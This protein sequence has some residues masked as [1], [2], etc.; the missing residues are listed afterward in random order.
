MKTCYISG[1]ISGLKEDEYTRN[2]DFAKSIVSLAG[3][4]P[5][6]PLDLYCPINLWIAYMIV[7][8]IVLSFC[9]CVYFMDGWKESRGARIEYKWAKIFRKNILIC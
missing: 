7:D 2:F 9:D 4:K 5:I 3:F 8:I 1:K 6:S